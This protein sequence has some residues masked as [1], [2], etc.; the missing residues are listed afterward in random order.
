MALK[1]A[2]EI[3]QRSAEAYAL[4]LLAFCL[5]PQGEFARALQY[6]QQSLAI[7]QEIEHR[8]WITAAHCVSGALSGDLL[9]FSTAQQHFEQALS[10]AKEIRSMYW[11]HCSAAYLASTYILQ[12]ELARAESILND[13]L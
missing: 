11:I 9:D 4:L 6:A 8:Q 5:G 13:A 7:A 1:I 3:G 10:L 12:N 2:R